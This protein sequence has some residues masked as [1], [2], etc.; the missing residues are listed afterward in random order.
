MSK[1][2]FSAC[3]IGASALMLSTSTFASTSDPVATVWDGTT[4]VVNSVTEPLGVTMPTMKKMHHMYMVTDV[5]TGKSKM[6]RGLC[7]HDAIMTPDMDSCMNTVFPGICQ[8]VKYNITDEKTGKEYR[9]LRV[10]EGTMD[11]MH[12]T[13]MIRYQYVMPVVKPL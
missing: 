10:K 4:T 8:G 6:V 11:V 9:V 3:L 13:K 7:G 12:G 1:L 5:D 2:T